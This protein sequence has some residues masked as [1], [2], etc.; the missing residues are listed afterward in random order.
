[1]SIKQKKFVD[2]CS[3]CG[4]GSLNTVKNLIEKNKSLVNIPNKTSSTYKRMYP[5]HFACLKG[6]IEIVK[7]LLDNGAN[8]N[9]ISIAENVK[10]VHGYINYLPIHYAYISKNYELVKFLIN[11]G[12][13]I[14]SNIPLLHF[15]CKS[16]NLDMIKLLISDYKIN[17][18]CVNEDKK[19]CLHI[20]CEKNNIAMVK[21]LVENNIDVNL[22]DNDNLQ[23]LQYACKYNNLD[24]VKYLVE[25]GANIYN[26]P[27]KIFCVYDYSYD[28]YN[29]AMNRLCSS[30]KYI[31]TS[32]FM[33]GYTSFYNIQSIWNSCNVEIVKFL[34]E[35][36]KTYKTHSLYYLELIRKYIIYINKNNTYCEDIVLT[37]T[38]KILKILI[39]NHYDNGFTLSCDNYEKYLFNDKDNLYLNHNSTIIEP[40]IENNS[41][42]QSIINIKIDLINF[43]LENSYIDIN[44]NINNK[45]D[46]LIHYISRDYNNIKYLELLINYGADVN[47]YN[48]SN[49]LPIHCAFLSKKYDNMIF[50]IKNKSYL[51]ETFTLTK[52]STILDTP[53]TVKTCLFLEI[54]ETLSYTSHSHPLLGETK[55]YEIITLLLEYG[56][57]LHGE[58]C[59]EIKLLCKK[60]TKL[61]D[62]MKYNKL[63]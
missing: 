14:Y 24:I 48:K 49:L 33:E 17:I 59:D 19:S 60:N 7:L 39:K 54:I 4:N 5:I 1:M 42:Y 32:V 41:Y 28:E 31:L 30:D 25:N 38:V 57:D 29:N 44:S 61:N 18:N 58:F 62:L 11:K 35:S 52:N 50:L 2:L 6:H 36:D 21:I 40:L 13:N 46:K 3:A 8:I 63:Y 23:A 22:H 34:L 27:N 56:I 43:L 12:A 47:V 45:H 9:Q 55:K 16:N 53:Y 26:Y 20:A 15:S 10:Y 37:N 51:N